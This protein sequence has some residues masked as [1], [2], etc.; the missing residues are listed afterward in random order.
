MLPMQ[1]TLCSGK[2]KRL[3]TNRFVLRPWYEVSD[4]EVLILSLVEADLGVK[5]YCG[6]ATRVA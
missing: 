6:N 1:P 2:M 4:Q 3:V 5:G